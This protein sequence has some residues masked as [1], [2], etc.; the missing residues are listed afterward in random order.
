MCGL[1]GAF[2]TTRKNIMEDIYLGLYALQHRGQES[3]VWR[4]STGRGISE[5]GWAALAPDPSLEVNTSRAIG[6]RYIGWVGSTPTPS[7]REL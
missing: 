5:R 4:G 6:V 2:S 7:R 3:A 1:F